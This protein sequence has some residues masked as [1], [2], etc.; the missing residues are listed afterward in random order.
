MA[1][2]FEAIVEAR[3]NEGVA[4][5][6]QVKY[7]I[8]NFGVPGYQPP[9]EL[10][11]AEKAIGFAPQAMLYVATGR[12]LSRAAGYMIEVVNKKLDIPYPELRDLMAK[13]GIVPGTEEAT[14]L[15]RLEPYRSELLGF[16]YRHIADETRR[17]GAVPVWIFLPQVAQ[18][19]RQP[20]T[21]E[22]MRL[23][24]EA[25]FVVIDLSNVYEGQDVASVRLAEWD[26]HPNVR[27]HQLIATRLLDA[28]E[29]NRT[30]IFRA[31]RQ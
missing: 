31:P 25:G 11:A 21:P 4:G 18:N 29:A 27:G 10:V 3:L 15:K 6:P 12:E 5:L 28:L 19:A 24:R 30:A 16:V 23:A 7:E 9:Q 22:Q 1:R 20:E 13:A 14:G 26:D 8:L 17:A 2:R